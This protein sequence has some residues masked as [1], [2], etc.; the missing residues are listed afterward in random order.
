VSKFIVPLSKP[1]SLAALKEPRNWKDF[2]KTL[3]IAGGLAVAGFGVESLGDAFLP[4]GLVK[5]GLSLVVFLIAF[6]AVNLPIA[7]FKS[8]WKTNRQMT[9]QPPV[10]HGAGYSP[11]T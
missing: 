1:Y 7:A 6:V 4:A 11:G 10:L 2:H 5:G 3:F 8:E 9:S